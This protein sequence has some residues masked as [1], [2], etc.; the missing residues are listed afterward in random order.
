MQ[1]IRRSDEKIVCKNYIEN[2]NELKRLKI[3]MKK[4]ITH[5]KIGWVTKTVEFPTSGIILDGRTFEILQCPVTF[6][7]R[8]FYIWPVHFVDSTKAAQVFT[9]TGLGQNTDKVTPYVLSPVNERNFEIS[10]IL[11]PTDPL[12]KEENIP[13]ISNSAKAGPSSN[14]PI[15]NLMDSM[16]LDPA[17]VG[18]SGRYQLQ[19]LIDFTDSSPQWNDFGSDLPEDWEKFDQDEIGGKVE[20]S[21]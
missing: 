2:N 5:A 13:G 6:D 18:R 4:D 10:T 9:F 3:Y 16:I 1:K 19:N 20:G 14:I 12:K 8:F 17:K 21:S 11:P 7:Q 15:P